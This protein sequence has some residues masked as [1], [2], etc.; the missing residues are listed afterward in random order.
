MNMHHGS[1]AAL[2][3]QVTDTYDSDKTFE[4]DLT[5]ASFGEALEE[6]EQVQNGKAQAPDWWAEAER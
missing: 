3:Y 6:L 4:N 2:K 5:E 1:Q